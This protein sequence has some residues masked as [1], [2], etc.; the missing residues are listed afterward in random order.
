L[1]LDRDDQPIG[2][3]FTPTAQVSSDLEC[4]ARL[5]FAFKMIGHS[6]SWPWTRGSVKLAVRRMQSV[7]RRLRCKRC[8]AGAF[9]SWSKDREPTVNLPMP[10]ERQWKR[11]L[12]RL[13]S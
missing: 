13:R 3:S 10:S 4:G 6:P 9:V 1:D 8:G 7:A 12:S 2:L 5:Q 11:A